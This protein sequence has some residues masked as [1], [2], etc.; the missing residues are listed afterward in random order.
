MRPARGR[1]A[2]QGVGR[3]RVVGGT[4]GPGPAA[5]RPGRA[6]TAGAA[7]IRPV[8]ADDG[9]NRY[10][11]FSRAWNTPASGNTP[12]TEGA[13]CTKPNV[14]SALSHIVCLSATAVSVSASPA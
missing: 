11:A 14:R 1:W 4:A 6:L 13:N 2:P 12:G 8:V 9:A 5:R 7:T 3:G 10:G